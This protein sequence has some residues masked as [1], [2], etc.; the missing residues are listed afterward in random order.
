MAPHIRAALLLVICLGLMTTASALQDKAA[1]DFTLKSSSGFNLRLSEHRGQVIMLNFWATW[2][3]PCRQEIPVLNAL[4]SEFQPLG[5]ELLGVNIDE[6]PGKALKMAEDLNVSY[7]VLFDKEKIV[8]KLYGVKAMPT[9][10]LIDRSGKVRHIH[11][12]YKSSY[13]QL[14]HEQISRLMRE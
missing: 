8:S 6:Q 7:P 4:H 2:C 9:T 12:G 14:Y 5:F 11:H 10:V 3:G 13:D 1:P